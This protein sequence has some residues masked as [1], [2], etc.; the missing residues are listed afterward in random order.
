MFKE[1]I[2]AM[3]ERYLRIIGRYILGGAIIF[4]KETIVLQTTIGIIIVQRLTERSNHSI[5][6]LIFK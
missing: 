2:T 6:P 5:K 1:P 3:T 4:E